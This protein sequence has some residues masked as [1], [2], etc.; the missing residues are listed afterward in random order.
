MRRI[1]LGLCAALML[2]GCGGGGVDAS[3]IATAVRNTEAAGGAEVAFQANIEVP[4]QSEPLVMTGSGLEDARGEKASL[5]F[6]IP[7]VGEMDMVADGLT[8]YMR[9]PMLTDQLGKD[10]VKIDLERAWEALGI[11]ADGF[12]Q[13]GQKPSDQ[14][15]MLE[16]V[17]DG[18]SEHG[19][20]TVVGVQAT[21]YSATIDLRDYPGQDLDKLI[22][23]TGQSE[24]PVDV[25]VDDDQR[26]RRMRW[27]QVMRQGDVEVR[28]EMTAEYVRFG[29]PV[30]IEIPDGDD[31]LDATDLAVQQLEQ[32]RP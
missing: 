25:W 18:V 12:A 17:S 1:L 26:I 6:S 32:G 8:M 29:V 16:T 10:W 13:I 27:V 20:D 22:E 30:D 28:G 21:H 11:E 5:K 7:Q 15:R 14:L 23:L 2:G 19:R 31:V 24:I 9:M 3:L 4:G